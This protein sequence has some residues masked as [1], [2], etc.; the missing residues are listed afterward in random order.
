M[1][2]KLQFNNSVVLFGMSYC[3]REGEG[4]YYWVLEEN[5]MLYLIGQKQDLTELDSIWPVILSGNH[6]AVISSP[7]NIDVLNVIGQLLLVL[8]HLF[9]NFSLVLLRS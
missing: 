2:Y 6:V 4:G 5:Y 9:S 1:E 8:T 7:A 3:F